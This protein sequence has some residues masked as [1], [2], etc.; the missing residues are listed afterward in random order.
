MDRTCN[1]LHKPLLC[2][3]IHEWLATNNQNNLSAS[4][5]TTRLKS[6]C[7]NSEVAST[8]AVNTN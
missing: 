8:A 2:D 5:K 1:L 3:D 7:I 4:V 6:A